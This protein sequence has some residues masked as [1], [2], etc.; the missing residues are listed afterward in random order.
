M[1]TRYH[2]YKNLDPPLKESP[3][4]NIVLY[5][6]HVKTLSAKR[7]DMMAHFEKIIAHYKERAENAEFLLKHLAKAQRQTEMRLI[8]RLFGIKRA[9]DYFLDK[10]GGQPEEL[11]DSRG[12][13][14]WDFINTLAELLKEIRE[15]GETNNVEGSASPLRQEALPE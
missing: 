4:G 14:S 13:I 12:H 7:R 10:W 2:Y 11:N 1:I 6:D 8:A 15:D 3:S 5:L 9:I